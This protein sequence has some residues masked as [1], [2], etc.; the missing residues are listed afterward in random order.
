MMRDGILFI[1]VGPSGAGKNTLMRRVQQEITGLPQLATA[2]T[3]PQRPGEQEGREHHFVTTEEFQHL[4][5]TDALIEYQPVHSGHLYGTPRETVESAIFNGTDL[6]ADIEFLGAGKIYQA[7]PDHTVPIFVTPSSLDLLT[8]RIKQRGNSTSADLAHRLER[9]RFEMTFAPQSHYVLVN[10][11]V[12]P[13]TEHLR[14]IILSERARRRNDVT[15]GL[16]PVNR[17]CVHSNVIALVQ[18]EDCILAQ[19]VNKIATF[20]TFPMDNHTD[21]PHDVLQ[22]HL[23][24]KLSPAITVDTILDDRF[25][26]IAPHH[27]ETAVIPNDIFLYFYYKCTTTE[28]IAIPGWD[29]LPSAELKLSAPLRRLLH[30]QPDAL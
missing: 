30:T 26:F 1:L 7:Y 22:T 25:D 23:H 17:P 21:T 19:I 2:T 3:R 6:I 5:D 9:V 15:K 11:Y 18:H 10:D 14:Q 16:T 27:V 29:W 12:I 28:R 20:P 8:D 24:S 4:I 13:A